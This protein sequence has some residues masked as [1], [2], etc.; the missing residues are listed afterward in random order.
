MEARET[1]VS[2]I[3]R[4]KESSEYKMYPQHSMCAKGLGLLRPWRVAGSPAG[5]LT[6]LLSLLQAA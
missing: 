1:W 6:R 2:C 5:S 4:V 3:R